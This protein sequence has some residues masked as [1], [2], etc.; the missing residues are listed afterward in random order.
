MIRYGLFAPIGFLIIFLVL[1]NEKPERHPPLM[2]LFGLAVNLVVI[3]I[4]AISPPA[5]FFIYTSYALVFITVGPFLARMNVKTQLA[6]AAPLARALQRLRFRRACRPVR[7]RLPQHLGDHAGHRRCPRRA[8][9]GVPC[10]PPVPPTQGHPPTDEGLGRGAHEER[11]ALAERAPAAH[12]GSAEGKSRRHRRS[13]RRSDGAL[14]R[15][16]RLHAALRSDGAGCPR[17]TSRR[18]F[19]PLRRDRGPA[20]PREDQDDRRR[21]HGRGGPPHPP[22]GS[23]RSRLRDG[24]PHA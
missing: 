7:P 22:R 16:R 17:S 9:D 10:A 13:F 3:W 12:R 21:L 19:Q 20:R 11:V 18:H 5:G 24:A 14:Q 2:L 23:H 4:G 1:K 6:Y 8:S 15:R